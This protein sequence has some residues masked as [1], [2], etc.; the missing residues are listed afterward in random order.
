MG[1]SVTTFFIAGETLIEASTVSKAS[2]DTI[3][4]INAVKAAIDLKEIKGAF[5]QKARIFA[6]DRSGKKL[7]VEIIPN[8]VKV[9]CRLYDH[10][11]LN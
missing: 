8:T 9:Q 3:G 4:K 2:Q 5:E 6:Y 1:T 11:L 10:L 7:D